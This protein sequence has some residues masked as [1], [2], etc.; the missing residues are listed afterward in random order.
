MRA[1]FGAA[2][3]L[4]AFAPA[5]TAQNEA[6]LRAAFEGKVVTLKIDMP[7]TSQGVEVYPQ[8]GMPVNFR[9]VAERLKDNGTG[10]KMGQQIMVTKVV[11]KKNSHIEFQL[12]GGGYGTFGDWASNGSDVYVPSSGE[13]KEE[14]ALRDSIKAAKGPTKRKQ[15]ERELA[16]VRASRE[17]EDAR[18]KAEAQQANL[19]REASI[20]SKRAESG[21]R[22]NIRYR[23]GIPPEGLTPDGVM[24]ALAQYV[25]FPGA[26]AVATSNGAAAAGSAAAAPAAALAPASPAN[27]A[28]AAGGVTALRKGLTLKEVE[29]LLGPATTAN[30]VKEG[31]MTVMK[32]SYKHDG[33]K[34]EARFVSDVL[35]DFAITPQ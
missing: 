21:S 28:S 31:A 25:D 24:R 19:A 30:E 33:M 15:F 23:N 6:A 29:A 27:G 35:I 10:V 12:G 4:A 3:A 20:R 5:A 26:S 2:L 8:D 13:T 14:K 9:E 1:L 7:A 34:V 32:R 11:I 18:A 16:S 17:R 22:F